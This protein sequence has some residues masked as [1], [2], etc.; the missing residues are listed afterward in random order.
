MIQFFH[1]GYIA[2]IIFFKMGIKT[3]SF[4]PRPY[5]KRKIF[6][7]MITKLKPQRIVS[8]VIQ[9]SSLDLATKTVHPVFVK[10]NSSLF[11]IYIKRKYSLSNR[12]LK[13]YLYVVSQN[14]KD[15]CSNRQGNSPP[16]SGN[17]TDCFLYRRFLHLLQNKFQQHILKIILS[18]NQSACRLLLFS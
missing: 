14:A 10:F 13:M 4:V 2:G 8:Q 12:L 9:S 18:K 15:I 11:C 7:I 1:N 3:K 16:L 5:A 6:K 17:Q